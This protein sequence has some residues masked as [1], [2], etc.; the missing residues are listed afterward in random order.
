MDIAS[1]TRRD[2]VRGAATG[3]LVLSGAALAQLAAPGAVVSVR[4]FGAVAQPGRDNS[5]AIQ[6]A[7]D[8]LAARGGGVLEIDGAFEC[9]I[10]T[11][12]GD[13]LTLRGINGALVN[14]RIVVPEGRSNFRIDNLTM[15]T[16][17]PIPKAMP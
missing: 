2:L 3:G 10:L 4:S 15:S 11:V 17:V 5:R 14:A 1:P 6:R 12:S 16:S 8:A 9:G 7:M 13:N